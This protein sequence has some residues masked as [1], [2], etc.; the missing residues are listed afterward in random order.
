MIEQSGLIPAVL[1][2]AGKDIAGI[3]G[4]LAGALAS[5]IVGVA[6]IRKKR[7]QQAAS[8]RSKRNPTG[9]GAVSSRKE[10]EMTFVPGMTGKSGMV[11]QTGGGQP[12]TSTPSHCSGFS[13]G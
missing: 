10:K 2:L 4:T 3:V 6:A 13:C 5:V 11:T 7:Q 1:M 8:S 12:A 9:V